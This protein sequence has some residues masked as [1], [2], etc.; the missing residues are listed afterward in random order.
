MQSFG[1]VILISAVVFVISPI[2][3]D[4]FSL[5]GH[6]PGFQVVH[7]GTLLCVKAD[8]MYAAADEKRSA[9]C[10]LSTASIISATNSTKTF[11][12][13]S[14][15]KDKKVQ[16]FN[17]EDIIKHSNTFTKGIAPFKVQDINLEKQE[18]ITSYHDVGLA[19]GS[20][21]R[22]DK[23]NYG[24]I[25]SFNVNP[26]GEIVNMKEIAG[27]EFKNTI[28]EAFVKANKGNPDYIKIEAAKILYKM[29]GSEKKMELRIGVREH[30]KDYKNFKY[31]VMVF[32]I[33]LFLNEKTKQFSLGNNLRLIRDDSDKMPNHGISDLS[34]NEKENTLLLLTSIELN[35]KISGSLWSLDYNYE[36]DD[37]SKGEFK[38]IDT[39]GIFEGHKPE[40]LTWI[41]E[42]DILVIA[43]EDREISNLADG[44]KRS[45][46]ESPFWVVKL[47]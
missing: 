11:I 36:K 38:P 42:H 7:Q 33:E 21:S 19:V 44:S 46:K 2:S 41:D 24:K 43:D 37:L 17:P 13:S 31:S 45:L 34:Y 12:L 25:I 35:D 22:E 4:A 3:S 27:P 30:G 28:R 47:F 32:G 20:Y 1:K 5:R 15:D 29:T 40:G 9:T 23:P 6:K 10:E 14:H 39:K 8:D 16:I 18:A 26:E